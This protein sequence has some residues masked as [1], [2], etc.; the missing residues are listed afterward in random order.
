MNAIELLGLFFI[1]KG[2]TMQLN[3]IVDLLISIVIC[4]IG[5]FTCLVLAEIDFGPKKAKVNK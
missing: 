1:I 2:L 3:N 4:L 5:I